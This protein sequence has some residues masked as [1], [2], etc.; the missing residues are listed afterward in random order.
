MQFCCKVWD[1]VVTTFFGA[2]SGS[3]LYEFGM[4]IVARQIRMFHAFNQLNLFS[5]IRLS[6]IYKDRILS[7]YQKGFWLNSELN[8]LAKLMDPNDY[9]LVFRDLKDAFRQPL[10]KIQRM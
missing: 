9:D 1:S 7:A 10:D 3:V 8:N 2:Q 6:N 4:Y 5:E